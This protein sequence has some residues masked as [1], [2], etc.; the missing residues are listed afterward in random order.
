LADKSAEAVNET[1]ILINKS[2]E[3]AREGS[4][5]TNKTA[6]ALS[7]VSSG[8]NNVSLTLSALS[9]D[10][11]KSDGSD[12]IND[13]R[14]FN[15]KSDASLENAASDLLRKIEALDRG[16]IFASSVSHVSPM[17]KT[18]PKPEPRPTVAKPITEKTETKQPT[19]QTTATPAPKPQPP[20][21]QP[22]K[23][24]PKPPEVNPPVAKPIEKADKTE[25]TEKKQ[26]I[27]SSDT[28]PVILSSS[29]IK[30]PDPAQYDFDSTNYGKY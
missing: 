12:V 7:Q 8:I 23:A 13:I 9:E 1:R 20:K 27:K 29:N 25:K 2:I 28:K 18:E 3:N 22:P 24:Q 26:P 10:A 14:M 30:A 16:D 17:M 5:L 11:V 21:P 6:S 15:S 19:T 4:E